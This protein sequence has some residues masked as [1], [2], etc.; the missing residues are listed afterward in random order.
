MIRLA[1]ISKS[2]GQGGFALE[3]ISFHVPK[4]NFVFITGPSGAGKTTLLSLLYG[5]EAA[6]K[7]QVFIAGRNITRIRRRDLP[8]LRRG[9]GVVFQD[10]KLISRRTVFENIE[11]CQR[12]IGVP[13]RE[14]RRRVY[15][16]LKLVD[17]A[18]KRDLYPRFLS[19]GEQ[20]RAAI[21]RALVNRPL[22]L[23]AD[24]PTG[25]LDDLMA[26]EVMD[27]FRTVNQM[28]TT[29]VVATHNKGLI[30]YGGGQ[31]MRLENGQVVEGG[32]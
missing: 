25:N 28:G 15:A 14:T 10:F 12:A 22:L 19:G 26:R 8:H 6:E 23:V 1:G 13:P 32:S 29:V 11:F 31:V 27:L 9:I 7:G 3:D 17:L 16:V 18:A 30:E 4:G 2:Y 24:E 21:A 5:A 20:Q